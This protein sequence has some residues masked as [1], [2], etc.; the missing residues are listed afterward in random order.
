MIFPAERM[1]NEDLEQVFRDSAL[2][3]PEGY[4]HIGLGILNGTPT[5]VICADGLPAMCWRETRWQRVVH[6]DAQA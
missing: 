4:T 5:L 1:S 6:A 3:M 2:P